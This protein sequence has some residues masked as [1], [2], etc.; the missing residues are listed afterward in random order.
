[1]RPRLLVPLVLTLALPA[2]A[3]PGGAPVDWHDYGPSTLQK[4]RQEGKPL[5]VLLTATWCQWC[6]TYEEESLH[7][8]E[9][10]ALLN[11]RYVPVW[12]DFDRRPD[13][14][15]RFPGRGLPRTI[16]LN[17]A[18]GLE[19]TV[20][21]YIP[22]SQLLANLR[23]TLDLIAPG[24]PPSEVPRQP[25]ARPIPPELLL[26]TASEEL[27]RQYDPIY[28]G[29]GREAKMPY[30]GVLAF[31]LAGS[32]S[33]RQHAHETFKAIAGDADW[34]KQLPG[35]LFDPREGGFFRY[36][37]RRNWGEPHSEK[38]LGLNAQL[39]S[40]A[41]TLHRQTLAP[42]SRSWAETTLRYLEGRLGTR[43]GEYYGSQAA[44][45]AYYRLPPE[46]RRKRPSPAI[47]RRHYA[48]ASAQMALALFE[49]EAVLNSPTYGR[50]A[51]AAIDA[52]T[53]R[54]D[55][56]GAVAHDWTGA[57]ESALRG[58]LE[59]QA[60]SALA[61][62][63]AWQRTRKPT[64]LRHA[65]AVLAFVERER[66]APGGYRLGEEGPIGVEANAAVALAFARAHQVTGKAT[67]AQ[68]ARHALIEGMDRNLDGGYG[69]LAARQLGASRGR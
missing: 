49:A 47:D 24:E 8:P 34:Q 50:K 29:F 53:R 57:E 58:L 39:V 19:A 46:E 43:N 20:A 7:T 17:P 55:P 30:P 3:A 48:A 4:A 35:G 33:E 44:D 31:L 69:W 40:L 61:L 51:R 12:V 45:S 62:L 23:K 22:K 42:K 37:T 66:R 65:E 28:H 14:A 68:K 25:A 63:E 32:D 60:W 5:F 26:Q 38:L 27:Q 1:M 59:D 6:H 9:V 21:G 67:Y 54:I 41:L 10:A 16:I 2:S 11:S 18:G 52:L 13:V 36:S 15:A 64:Y 56:K